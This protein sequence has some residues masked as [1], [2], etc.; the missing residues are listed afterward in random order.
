MSELSMEQ[1]AGS[2]EP[3]SRSRDIPVPLNALRL[4]FI[5]NARRDRNVPA[6]WFLPV[7]LLVV[8]SACVTCS[9][10]HAEEIRRATR[11]VDVL[12]V[13]GAEARRS[14]GR[15]SKIRRTRGRLRLKR[16]R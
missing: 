11:D 13:M 3:G 14:M 5:K 10:A 8:L 7:A 16:R 9:S 2:M 6:P 1:G 15:S 12:V 4:P